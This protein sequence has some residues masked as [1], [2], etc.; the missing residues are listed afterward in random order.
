MAD[1]LAK[2]VFKLKKAG[3]VLPSLVTFTE[4][5]ALVKLVERKDQPVVDGESADSTR[6]IETMRF[7]QNFYTQAQRKLAEDY[8]KNRRIRRNESLL[9]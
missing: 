1:G 5:Q 2:E 8:N 6:R 9:R 3:E 4:K 7:A